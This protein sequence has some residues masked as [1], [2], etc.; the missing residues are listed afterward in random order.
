MPKTCL[1]DQCYYP[2]WGKGY[3]KSHQYLRSDKNKSGIKPIAD[4]RAEEIKIYN[5]KKKEYLSIFTE[6]EVRECTNKSTHI[7]HKNGRTGKR[8]YDDNFFMAVCNDCHP[9]KIH[10]NPEWARENG[11]LV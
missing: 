5:T 1:L 3:C 10:E 8:L 6:C 7:H 9:Q 2:R 11:Y 4:K